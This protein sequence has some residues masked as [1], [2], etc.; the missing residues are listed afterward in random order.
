[1]TKTQFLEARAGISKI[2]DLLNTASSLFDQA[3]PTI[4][5]AIIAHHNEP[6]TLQHCL[7][8]GMQIAKELRKDWPAVVSSLPCEKERRE[9]EV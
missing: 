5:T 9:H 8:W 7:R 6:A 2:E 4:Q 3:S 1:V